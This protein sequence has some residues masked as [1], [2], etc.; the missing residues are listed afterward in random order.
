MGA[1]GDQLATLPNIYAVAHVMKYYCQRLVKQ[2]EST[3]LSDC[4]IC[5]I[6]ANIFVN[7]GLGV[8]MVVFNFFFLIISKDV[9]EAIVNSLA[10]FL[11]LE[12]DDVLKPKWGDADFDDRFAQSS[13]RCIDGGGVEVEIISSEGIAD[14]IVNYSNLLFH[15]DDRAHVILTEDVD[16]LLVTVYWDERKNSYSFVDS[17][18]YWQQQIK[19][20][21]SRNFLVGLNVRIMQQ[22]ISYVG[23]KETA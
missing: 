9:N 17:H 12:M 4:P 2:P 7:G 6:L 1:D 10:P 3:H 20:V 16:K 22:N 18:I 5:L 14:A 11:I 8:V 21:R 23:S 13:F 15:S 19:T